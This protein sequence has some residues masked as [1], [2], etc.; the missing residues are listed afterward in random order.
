MII[1]GNISLGRGVK[2]NSLPIPYGEV[3]FTANT[4][5]DFNNPRTGTANA[6]YRWTVPAGVTSISVLCIGGGGA[7]G[8]GTLWAESGNSPNQTYP[9]S[10]SKMYSGGGGGGGGLAYSNNLTVVPGTE[11]IIQV[12]GGG[13]RNVVNYDSMDPDY[14]DASNSW[15]VPRATD[16]GAS[17]FTTNAAIVAHQTPLVQANGG[18]AGFT[19]TMPTYDSL[20][21][22]NLLTTYW[23]SQGGG[24]GGAAGY[25]GAGGAGGSVGPLSGRISGGNGGTTSGTKKSA[26]FSGGAG[27]AASW[28]DQGGDGDIP[29]GAPGRGSNPAIGSGGGG[30]GSAEFILSRKQQNSTTTWKTISTAEF[31]PGG[32]TGAYGGGGV[33]IYGAG[34]DGKTVEPAW[35][36]QNYGGLSTGLYGEVQGPHLNTYVKCSGSGGADGRYDQTLFEYS[37]LVPNNIPGLGASSAANGSSTPSMSQGAAYGGG[38]GADFYGGFMQQ[39]VTGNWNNYHGRFVPIPGIAVGGP[40]AVRIVWP[41]TT[42]QFPST[43]VQQINPRL[44]GIPDIDQDTSCEIEILC[45]AGGGCGGAG[46]YAFYLNGQYYYSGGGGAG[47]GGMARKTVR[48]RKGSRL[49]F[50]VGAGGGALSAGSSTEVFQ[51]YVPD[52]TGSELILQALGGG[53]GGL[54]GQAWVGTT[55]WGHNGGSGGGSG[56]YCGTTSGVN[57]V[58]GGQ[59]NPGHG[60]NGYGQIVTAYS[61]A[62]SGGGC[63]MLGDRKW[64]YAVS[65]GKYNSTYFGRGYIML[66]GGGGG[67]GSTGSSYGGAGGNGGGGGGALTYNYYGGG[68]T[69]SAEPGGQ[70]TGGG[71]GGGGG[72]AYSYYTDYYGTRYAY[73][74]SLGARGG[75]GIVIIHL[76]SDSNLKYTIVGSASVS[77]QPD[78]S[79]MISFY[80][81]STITFD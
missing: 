75:S 30:G 44:L 57:G 81:S 50:Y 1:E 72:A 12:G 32:R 43:R 49:L 68:Y 4:I 10:A 73:S 23:T 74:N 8:G 80:D 17:F 7:G 62:G 28:I 33:G 6:M 51:S 16:G 66:A 59:G 22:T 77:P 34:D 60:S 5:G 11:Y 21:N 31:G 78:G 61:A 79:I 63:G 67:G 56:G 15:G 2:V 69:I 52:N 9:A 26:G 39:D 55:S 70:N 45:V 13:E 37:Y 58:G 54:A 20:S 18:I 47:G 24:G 41:G 76:P 65:E 40:G 25:K 27:G 64:I 35:D 48:V 14:G 71:G 46:S 3:V 29:V 36:N 53:L 19:N 42:R 38:G